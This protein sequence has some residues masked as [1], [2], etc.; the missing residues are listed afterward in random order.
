M[1]VVWSGK[2]SET[3]LAQVEVK[4][5]AEGAIVADGYALD[6]AYPNPFNAPFTLPLTLTEPMHVM[7]ELYSLTGQSVMRVVNRELGV[8][9][10]AYTVNADDLS[11]GMYLVRTAF[12]GHSHMQKVVLLK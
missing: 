1:G 11:S 12:N 6:P 10:Y 5:K 9:S 7:V 8:G 2:K 3:R 4:V